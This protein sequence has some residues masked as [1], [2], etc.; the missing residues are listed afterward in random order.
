MKAF[1]LVMTVDQVEESNLPDLIE[2]IRRAGR[3]LHAELVLI[4]GGKV[5]ITIIGED[6]R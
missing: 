1:R 6:L 2:I 5:E 3:K 4:T